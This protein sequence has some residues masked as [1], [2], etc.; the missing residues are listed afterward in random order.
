M[1]CAPANSAIR[2]ISGY[3]VSIILSPVFVRD[4][5]PVLAKKTGSGALYLKRREIFKSL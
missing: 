1:N 3:A 4:V 5:D 2:T